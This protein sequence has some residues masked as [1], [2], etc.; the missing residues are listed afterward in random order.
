MKR[1]EQTG[2]PRKAKW[3]KADKFAFTNS[4]LRANTVPDK[5]KEQA[6]KACRKKE[7]W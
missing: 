5:K 4:R 7:E 6:R 2:G 1:T 3:S